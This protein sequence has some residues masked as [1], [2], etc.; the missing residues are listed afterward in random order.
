MTSDRFLQLCRCPEYGPADLS[1]LLAADEVRRCDACGEL[2]A[3]C[4]AV[5]TCCDDDYR[6]RP[7]TVAHMGHAEGDAWECGHCRATNV[8][9]AVRP[10]APAEG[11][12]TTEDYRTFR[13]NGEAVVEVADGKLWRRAVVRRMAAGESYADVWHTDAAGVHTLLSR[14]PEDK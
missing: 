6:P 10:T 5:A 2:S 13:R 1:D 8:V 9:P 4:Y 14:D 7:G 11:D 12:Y 3:F